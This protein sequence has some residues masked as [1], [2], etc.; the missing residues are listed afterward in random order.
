MQC[1]VCNHLVFQSVPI[2][3]EKRTSQ[4]TSGFSP[5]NRSFHG[6]RRDLAVVKRSQITV[7]VRESDGKCLFPKLDFTQFGNQNVKILGRQLIVIT[8]VVDDVVF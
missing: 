7:F 5:D 2:D 6:F 1:S 8:K 4:F 3:S